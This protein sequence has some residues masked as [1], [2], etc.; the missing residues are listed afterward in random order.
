MQDIWQLLVTT[1]NLVTVK[2]PLTD[3]GRH[4]TVFPFFTCNMVVNVLLLLVIMY[5]AHT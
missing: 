5:A 3:I 4:S 2:A 1:W